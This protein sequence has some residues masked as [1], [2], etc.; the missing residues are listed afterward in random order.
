MS[1]LRSAIIAQI[2]ADA[3]ALAVVVML[4]AVLE[5]PLLL[6]AFQ[7]GLAALVARGLQAPAWWLAIHLAFMPL[8]VAASGLDIAPGWYLG[9]FLVLLA[10]FWRT[11]RSRVP[12]Y[13]SNRITADAVLELLP[14]GPC[15]VLDLG[16]GD[17][18][19]LR[20][21]ARSRPES[22]FLGIEHAPLPWAWARLAAAGSPN[23]EIRHGDFWR[24]PL[25]GFDLVYAFLSPAPMAR[26]W[27]KARGEMAA[28]ALLVS[29]SFPVPGVAAEPVLE[30][31][32]RRATRLYCYRPGNR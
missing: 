32:D 11:D 9:A 15:R 6:A 10:V 23:C 8:V 26:L 13:L 5:R 3:V 22:R 29:N 4:P 7:G 27:Q 21:L 30:L 20:R 16:C 24:H 19:L 1:P 18:A 28:D 31:A 17:G 25:S 12:L 14:P 2:A